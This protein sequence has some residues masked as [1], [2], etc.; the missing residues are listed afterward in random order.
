MNNY[1][2]ACRSINAIIFDYVTELDGEK[3]IDRE[4]LF[5]FVVNDPEKSIVQDSCPESQ[6][7]GNVQITIIGT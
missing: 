5:V 4:R 3:N 1:N 6:A 7:Q 2:T